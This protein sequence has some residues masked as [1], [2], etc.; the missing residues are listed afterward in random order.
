[1][2]FLGSIGGFF[3]RLGGYIGHAFVSAGNHGLTD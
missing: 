1:M 3:K 2:S